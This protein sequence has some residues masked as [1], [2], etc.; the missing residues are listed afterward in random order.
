VLLFEA[1]LPVGRQFERSEYIGGLAEWE[2]SELL[3]FS[4]EQMFRG[5]HEVNLPVGRQFERSE[6]IGG[7]AEWLKA[8]VY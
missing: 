6:Y 8:A 1:N 4:P 2:K 3:H 7:L 5:R